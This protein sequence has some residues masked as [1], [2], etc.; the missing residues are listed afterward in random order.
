MPVS[1]G[2]NARKLARG[3]A[4]VY[5]ACQIHIYPYN[6]HYNEAGPGIRPSSGHHQAIILHQYLHRL[7]LLEIRE[8]APTNSI[9]RFR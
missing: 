3:R 9:A 1:A 6:I 2:M 5:A 8:P 4:S 7:T